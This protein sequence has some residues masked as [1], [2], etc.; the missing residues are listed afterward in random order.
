MLTSKGLR[1]GQAREDEP[2]LPIP[3]AAPKDESQGVLAT[4]IE[5]IEFSVRAR[6]ALDSLKIVTMGDLAAKSEAELMG[7]KNFGQTSLNEIR[8]R[9]SEYGLQ[10]RET[11]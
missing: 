2:G 10:L 6:R 3:E 7:C 11:T 5:S 1:L 8:Q 9:L 4:R